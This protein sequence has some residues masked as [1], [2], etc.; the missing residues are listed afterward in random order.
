MNCPYALPTGGIPRIT[1]AGELLQSW[2]TDFSPQTKRAYNADVAGFLNFLAKPLRMVTTDDVQR[3]WRSLSH[4][5]PASQ[6]RKL[7]VVRSL[8]RFGHRSGFFP[9]DVAAAVKPLKIE[10]SEQGIADWT[11]DEDDV[12]RMIN[13]ERDPRNRALLGLIYY[14]ELRTSEV[15]NLRTSDLRVNGEGCMVTVSGKRPKMVLLNDAVLGDLVRLL[16]SGPDAPVFRSRKGGGRLDASTVHRIV[17]GAA[18]GV[19]LPG[20]VSAGSLRYAHISHAFARGTALLAG[21]ATLYD[22]THFLA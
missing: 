19:G 21:N 17:V 10:Q 3:Y 5:S 14:G 1:G 22:R 12:Q 4:L 7:S 18:R 6:N 11:L 15:C 9:H 8:I 20:T 2:L 16:A 13:R